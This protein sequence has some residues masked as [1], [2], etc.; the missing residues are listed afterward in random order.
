MTPAQMLRIHCTALGFLAVILKDVEQDKQALRA[1]T[2][3]RLI[4]S[5]C[6][7]TVPDALG[8]SNENIG[9]EKDPALIDQAIEKYKAE[10]MNEGSARLPDDREMLLKFYD[11]LHQRQQRRK[12]RHFYATG[13][14]DMIAN[15]VLRMIEEEINDA[16]SET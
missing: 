5:F 9:D 14:D 2:I 4:E 16:E 8:V 6:M 3:G 13:S 12:E 15:R 1:K 7:V 11:R 10:L